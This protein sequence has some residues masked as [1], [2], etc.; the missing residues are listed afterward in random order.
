MK[1]KCFARLALLLTIP[2]GCAALPSRGLGAET[3]AQRQTEWERVVRAAGKEGQ[4]VLYAG[5]GSLRPNILSEFQKDYPEVKTLST[6]GASSE[7]AP[8]LL[9]ERRA[10]K[11]LAD[12]YI[13]GPT[14]L[15]NVV[16]KAKALDPIAPLL[17][18]P[19]VADK[20]LWWEGKHFYIDPEGQ[21]IFVNE[22]SVEGITIVYNTNLVKAEEFRSYWDLLRPKWKG[23]IVAG[24]ARV[25]G[26]GTSE[27]RY[28]Y[29]HPE[30]GPDF[31][32]RLY[33]EMDVFLTRDQRQGMDW[34]GTGK[35]S[36][37]IFCRAPDLAKHQGLPV[38]DIKPAQL[39]E[40]PR[41]RG[42][43]S[44]IAVLNR[45]PHPNAA[46]LFINWFLSRR[47]QTVYQSSHELEGSPNSLREDISKEVVPPSS[48]REK[49]RKYLFVEGPEF[50]DAKPAI[51][52]I[53]EALAAKGKS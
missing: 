45:A 8:R 21:Y 11:Y 36:F 33:G 38:D 26:L 15:Y 23:R 24:D 49:G 31:I 16:H 25:A 13:G 6:T 51:N 39:K 27:L 50:M 18:L 3:A 17:V 5:R 44:T 53:N 20:S 46:K 52:V 4:V 14:T 40:M 10:G 12:V 28:I 22:G 35:F 48:R 32:R 19:E 1:R 7:I 2:F 41:L 43:S 42:S 30:L 37:C 47:G 34:V 9:S 29:Y